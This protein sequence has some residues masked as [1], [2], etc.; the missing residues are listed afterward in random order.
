MAQQK[1]QDFFDKNMAA[2]YDAR[3]EKIRAIN[4]CLHL[5]TRLT[6]DGLPADASILCV[7]VGTGADILGVA[8]A[9]PRW[10]FTGVDP[11]EHML[12]VCRERMRAHGLLE[13]CELVHGHLADIPDE[14]RFDAVLC[15]LVTQFV[16][17]QAA[18]QEMFRGMA[19]RLKPGGY[20]V[21]AEISH[22]MASPEF[23]DMAEKWKTMHSHAAGGG[24]QAEG[25]LKALREHVAVEPQ[26]VI[27]NYLR[28]GGLSLPVQFFQ[29]LLIRAWY[30]RKK[31]E[32][33][34]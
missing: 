10:R 9:F 3:F 16:K 14:P 5:L 17:D 2:K 27:E 20:L 23:Q 31:P 34:G 25:A 26:P 33:V 13:R 24:Q 22:D 15:L 1:S 11:S 32:S 18:R 8:E 30:S 21:N 12:A 7:G 6:L 28:E 4:D 29:A 19:A